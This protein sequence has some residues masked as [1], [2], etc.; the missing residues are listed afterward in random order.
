M[1]REPTVH[2]RERC[3]A[4]A[5]EG[6]Q[7]VEKS[8]GHVDWSKA[9]SCDTCDGEGHVSTWIGIGEFRRLLERAPPD[10]DRAGSA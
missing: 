10:P 9:V 7:A 3:P 1:E 4:C 6:S 5:G 8:A 2:I